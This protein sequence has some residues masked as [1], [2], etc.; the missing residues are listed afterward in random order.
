MTINS[1]IYLQHFIELRNYVIAIRMVKSFQFSKE[2]STIE[3]F[4][5]KRLRQEIYF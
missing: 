4:K 1:L 5:V 3:I 2:H